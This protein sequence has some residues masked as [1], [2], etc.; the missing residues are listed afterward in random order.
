MGLKR[1]ML[2][3]CMALTTI[4]FAAPATASATWLKHEEPIAQ[5]ENLEFT[6]SV[7]FSIPGV[8]SYECVFH[9]QATLEAGTT[10]GRINGSNLTPGT[11]SGTGALAGCTFAA[12]HTNGL[13]W[14][15]HA[16]PGPGNLSMTDHTHTITYANPTTPQCP[17]HDST[18]NFGSI[19][20][21]PDNTRVVRRVS[22][23]GTGGGGLQV[24]GELTVLPEETF[25]FE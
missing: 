23:S 9:T 4:A 15:F 1:I 25:G 24:S 10:T 3:A 19:I 17:I 7:N 13:P 11:C 6:G 5:N 2:L 16:N 14:T 18:I 20:A 8:A 12:V 21:V 22:L